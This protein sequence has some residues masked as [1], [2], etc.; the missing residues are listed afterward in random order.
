MTVCIGVSDLKRNRACVYA[1]SFCGN[2]YSKGATSDS[3]KK[4]FHNSG[5]T[6][7][8]TTSFLGGRL[9]QYKWKPPTK[10]EGQCDNEYLLLTVNESIRSIFNK[11]DEEGLKD[12]AFVFSYK[13]DVYHYHNKSNINQPYTIAERFRIVTCG[14]GQDYALAAAYGIINQGGKDIDMIAKK[15][16][17]IACE[18]S[19]LCTGPIV[20]A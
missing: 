20:S 7:A 5:F 12:F 17:E 4:I 18:L 11:D 6:I 19:P 9:L 15:S 8:Y 16:L 10:I 3:S 13:N 14:A 2:T 1:D